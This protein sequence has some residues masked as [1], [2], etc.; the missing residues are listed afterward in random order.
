MPLICAESMVHRT[1]LSHYDNSW[2]DA[3]P[4]FRRALWYIAHL[5]FFRSGFPFNSVKK[6]LLRAFG[7]RVGQ[8]VVI[9]PHVRIKYPW[10]LRIGDYSWIGE[11]A[12]LDNLADVHIGSNCCISQGAMLLCGNHDYSRR[13]FDLV[14]KPIILEDGAWVGARGLVCPGVIM[15]SH[16]VLA[17]GSVLSRDAEPYSVY[18]GNPAVKTKDREMKP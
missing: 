17:A 7:A 12:W 8:G 6:I 16:S 18:R 15:K 1:D 10:K 2:Y 5:L 9:K 11:E 14:I 4:V 3:G 13:S